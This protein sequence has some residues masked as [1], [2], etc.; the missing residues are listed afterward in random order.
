MDIPGPCRHSITKDHLLLMKKLINNQLWNGCSITYKFIERKN[1]SAVCYVKAALPCVLDLLSVHF[2]YAR[3][4]DSAL[5]VLSLKNLI[6]NIYSQRCVP[7]LNEELE[8]DPV[9]FEKEFT[10]SPLRALQRAEE[11]LVLYLQLITQTHTFVDWT[12][13]T[14]YSSHTAVATTPLPTSTEASLGL[15]EQIHQTSSE[16]SFYRLGFISLSI[17]S[18]GL[19]ILTVYCLI[20]RKQQSS[21]LGSPRQENYLQNSSSQATVQRIK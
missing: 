13:E 5:S 18:G 9:E 17:V 19:L 21:E 12:C 20:D 11:I 1:L 2:K 10:D 7:A 4:S 15:L 8:E 14:E 16:E 3:G 6:L